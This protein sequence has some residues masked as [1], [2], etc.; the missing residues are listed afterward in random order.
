MSKFAI[1]IYA[2][3][4]PH[5]HQWD[6]VL[7]NAA[8][9]ERFVFKETKNDLNPTIFATTAIMCVGDLDQTPL[10]TGNS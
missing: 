4:V 6:D 10:M 5:Y 1:S 9:E 7:L 8:I 2:A 3:M